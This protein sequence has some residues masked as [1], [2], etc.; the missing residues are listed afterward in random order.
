MSHFDVGVLQRKK[1]L[2][3]ALE[4]TVEVIPAHVNKCSEIDSINA[5]VRKPVH[6][7][8]AWHFPYADTPALRAHPRRRPIGVAAAAAGLTISAAVVVSQ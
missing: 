7:P 2:V 5:M 6:T 8:W 4:R 1:L 3:I